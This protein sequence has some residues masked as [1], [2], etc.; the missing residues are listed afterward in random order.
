M[1][2]VVC[3]PLM[4]IGRPVKS[5]TLGTRSDESSASVNGTIHAATLGV[6]VK[7][8]EPEAPV[9]ADARLSK[10]TLM[11]VTRIWLVVQQPKTG[12][13]DVIRDHI[14][15]SADPIVL[16]LTCQFVTELSV[17]RFNTKRWTCLRYGPV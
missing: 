12:V 8:T 1:F 3:R 15:F 6:A 16:L 4:D 14:E 17:A 5:S 11:F 9:T 13:G 7:A 10:T 2:I